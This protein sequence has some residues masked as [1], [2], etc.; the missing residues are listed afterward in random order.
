M[1]ISAQT[2]EHHAVF[3]TNKMSIQEKKEVVAFSTVFKIL[4]CHQ[5]C[6][7]NA[8]EEQSLQEEKSVHALERRGGPACN[9]QAQLQF[10]SAFLHFWMEVMV[11]VHFCG[12]GREEGRESFL[13]P[14]QHLSPSWTHPPTSNNQRQTTSQLHNT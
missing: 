7:T 9:V 10:F 2:A 6:M 13:F 11:C 3:S 12:E 4:M 5:L 14:K 8:G 1:F